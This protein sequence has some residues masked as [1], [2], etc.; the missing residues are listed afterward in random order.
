MPR[1]EF[2]S[3][4]KTYPDGTPA[5]VDLNLDIKD[6]EFLCLL[7]PSGCGKSST[8][9]VLAGLEQASA[10][11]I[12][13]DGKRI[14]HL[15]TQA[16]DCAMV[17]ENYALYPHLTA[18][19]NIAMPLRARRLPEQ[20]VKERVTNVARLLRIEPLLARRPGRLSGGERQRVGI[21]RALVREPAVFLMD[22]PLGHL[23]AYF[24]VELRA[25][26]RRLQE[27][28]RITTIYVTHDQ[29]EAA[30]VADR[31]VV[32]NAGRLQQTGP[33]LDLF[34][35]PVNR[36]VAQFVGEPPMVFLPVERVA[37]NSIAVAGIPMPLTEPLAAALQS[38]G[39]ST[40]TLGIRPRDISV[41]PPAPDRLRG[42]VTLVQPQG[43]H[44]IVVL[45]TPVGPA[46]V[47]VPSDRRPSEKEVLGLVFASEG[48][49][50]FESAGNS[51]LQ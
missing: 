32:M 28:L 40:L 14:D 49:H 31:I 29:D 46:S 17:F 13:A 38:T 4:T 22:E 19:D 1:I 39:D 3:V 8:I 43:E 41:A 33:F 30:A 36:F 2:K 23:E 26:I 20:Q 24:R 37:A 9:R 47:I 45:T 11:A 7:G 25:E 34:D 21:G 42:E 5:V 6:G 10:G 12:L 48:L 27:R 44:A 18:F 51:V 35:R 15:P 16:R 50:L